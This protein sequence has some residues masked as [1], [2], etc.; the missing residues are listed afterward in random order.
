[1]ALVVDGVVEVVV[2]RRRHARRALVVDRAVGAAH[3]LSL[4][5]LGALL[6]LALVRIAAVR[7]AGGRDV[8]LHQIP[9]GRMPTAATFSPTV[10]SRSSRNSSLA[11]LAALVCRPRV[12]PG[13]SAGVSG[14][15]P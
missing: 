5:A 12:L 6:T 14:G 15:A 8:R 4:L 13:A 7:R 10:T 9:P 11:A 1:A 2:A 3:A